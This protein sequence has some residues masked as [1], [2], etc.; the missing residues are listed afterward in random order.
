MNMLREVSQCIQPFLYYNRYLEVISA[1][2]LEPDL[3]ILPDGDETE[4]N[5]PYIV[6]Y[7]NIT[8]FNIFN[9]KYVDYFDLRWVVSLA[10]ILVLVAFERHLV[11]LRKMKLALS[12]YHMKAD[13][14]F[15]Y[16][17]YSKLTRNKNETPI[18]LHHFCPVAMIGIMCLYNVF[19]SV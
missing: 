14:M 2:G 18:F 8:V 5:W 4:V 1:C 15:F 9:R 17:L 12:T 7:A 6:T 3:Q 11:Y 16:V 19:C 13:D 10:K